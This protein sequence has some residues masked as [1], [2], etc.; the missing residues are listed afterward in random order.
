MARRIVK[1][2]VLILM[3]WCVMTFTH[4]IGHVICGWAS[5][6]KL[7]RADLLPWRLPYSFFDPDPHPLI[8]LWGGLICGAILPLL[9]AVL[10]RRDWMW[11]IAHFCLLAN[12]VYV[13]TAWVSGDGFLDTPRL[14]AHGA[15][16]VAIALYCLLTIGVGYIGFRRQVLDVFLVSDPRKQAA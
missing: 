8:T 11:L 10:I 6:G 4:E 13:A 16:P 14:L 2:V 15:D 7:K 1:F 3:A 5:G 12:G 9:L